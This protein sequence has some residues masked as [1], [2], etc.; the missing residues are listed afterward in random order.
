MKTVY[1]ILLIA[2]PFPTFA[3]YQF[4]VSINPGVS[5]PTKSFTAGRTTY[6]AG[7]APCFSGGL[8]FNQFVGTS[9]QFGTRIMF[10]HIKSNENVR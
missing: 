3:Q 6:D 2:L 1:F 8:Y 4:G 5:M 9:F 7:L 10:N